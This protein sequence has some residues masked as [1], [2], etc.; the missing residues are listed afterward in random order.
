MYEQFVSSTQNLYPSQE[1]SPLLKAMWYDAKDEWNKAHD[2]AQNVHTAEGSWV[3][4][5]LHRKEGDISNARYWYRQAGKKEFQGSLQEEWEAIVK[6]L[7]GNHK[8]AG[9]K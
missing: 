6:T 7:L 5:Y 9:E 2:V 4:A 1:Y 8:A 3:H